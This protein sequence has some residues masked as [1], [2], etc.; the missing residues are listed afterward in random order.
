MIQGSQ[1]GPLDR[2][3]KSRKR[4]VSLPYEGPPLWDL[5]R[6]AWCGL[7]RQQSGVEVEYDLLHLWSGEIREAAIR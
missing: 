5:K 1:L 3:D 2:Q 6:T 7:N 4:R